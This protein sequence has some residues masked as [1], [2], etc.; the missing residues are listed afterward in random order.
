MSKEITNNELA[1]MIARGFEAT[2]TKKDLAEVRN[3]LGGLESRITE[4]LE[5]VDKRLGAIERR[6]DHIEEVVLADH[7]QRIRTL[8]EAVGLRTGA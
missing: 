4:R 2:A 5:R 3:D 1:R 8:E 7:L 6:L